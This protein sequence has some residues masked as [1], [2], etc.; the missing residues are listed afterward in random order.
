MGALDVDARRCHVAV[1]QRVLCCAEDPA[2]LMQA[3]RQSLCPCGIFVF[4]E[5]TRAVA[6]DSPLLAAAQKMMRPLQM[7]LC[8]GCD[9]CC[10]PESVL[11]A[12]GP[13]ATFDM[14]RYDLE[15]GLLITPHII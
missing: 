11:R 3:I 14:W 15:L 13:W 4:V 5:H 12:A 10:D 9:V 6:A 1:V 2:R 7:A 8:N